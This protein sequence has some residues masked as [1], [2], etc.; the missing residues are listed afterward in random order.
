MAEIIIKEI[1]NNVIKFITLNG[2]T[3]IYGEYQP[4]RTTMAKVIETFFNNYDT[5]Y[6][7]SLGIFSKDL[8]RELTD[9]DMGSLMSK[10]NLAKI[11]E[12]KIILAK[13]GNS[14][15]KNF[16]KPKEMESV[17]TISV[18]TEVPLTSNKVPITYEPSPRRTGIY[19]MQLFVRTL[20]GATVTLDVLSNDSIEEIKNKVQ[21][22]HGIPPDQQRMIFAGKQLEDG[23]TL[24][25]YNIQSD[26][27]IYL[28]E[29]LRGGMFH[30]TSGRNGKYGALK[31]IFF[32]IDPDD[33]H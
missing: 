16:S 32:M 5:G 18:V 31:P 22:K 30:E 6:N 28:V 7:Q 29:R 3:N 8:N 4:S 21:D 14:Y 10:F 26:S 24:E 2:S 19:E 9:D 1:N 33:F 25:D 20:T 11:S 15:I 23:R 13:I 27:T 12:F 17:E